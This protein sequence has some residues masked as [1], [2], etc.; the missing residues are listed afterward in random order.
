MDDNN[1]SSSE[2]ASWPV[3]ETSQHKSSK[4]QLTTNELPLQLKNDE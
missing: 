3:S 1:D 4:N 2:S